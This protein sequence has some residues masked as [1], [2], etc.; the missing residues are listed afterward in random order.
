MGLD[1]FVYRVSKPHLD[2]ELVYDYSDLDGI[3]ISAYDVDDPAVTE[4][5]SKS[6]VTVRKLTDLLPYTQLVKVRFKEYDMKRIQ[7]DFG[8]PEQSYIGGSS[9]AKIT[10]KSRNG[11]KE[12]EIPMSTVKKKYIVDVVENCLFAKCEEVMYWRKAYDVQAWFHGEIQPD[13]ENVG[14]YILDEYLLKEYNEKY[15]DYRFP[16]EIP[17][18]ESA[19][20]YHEWY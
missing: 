18:G 7:K 14:Y 10:V 9:S 3:I 20:F 6:D 5:T 4:L 17:C 1:M 8:L 2:D 15:P 19:L 16:F 12:L 11:G 13:V